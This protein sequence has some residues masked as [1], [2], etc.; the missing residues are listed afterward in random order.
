MF[1]RS[2][3]TPCHIFTMK[4]MQA[5]PP[6]A[7]EHK[8]VLVVDEEKEFFLH[9][10][11]A[12][13]WLR[14]KNTA[15]SEGV[16]LNLI[17]AFRSV[18]RQREIIENKRVR[19]ISEA[20]IFRVSA[21]A[22]FSEHHS[23]RAIDITTKGYAPLEE[24]GRIEPAP[25]ALPGF[26]GRLGGNGESCLYEKKTEDWP[27]FESHE[28]ALLLA[29]SPEGIKGRRICLSFTAISQRQ[30]PR[31]GWWEWFQGWGKS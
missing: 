1:G 29:N 20:E 22:G 7:E 28:H 4:T 18:S 2:S 25:A 19:G 14:M 5:L 31:L 9:P 16:D 27:P 15:N 17:S 12:Q 11:A 6:V 10:E 3:L 23:G 8:L 24:K 30:D 26:F 13:A 21:L